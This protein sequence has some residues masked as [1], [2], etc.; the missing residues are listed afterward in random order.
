MVTTLGD[1]TME[2]PDFPNGKFI[3]YHAGPTPS[4]DL[5]HGLLPIR[6]TNEDPIYVLEQIFEKTEL[7]QIKNEVQLE[8]NEEI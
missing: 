8:C 1:W 7:D 2:T 3:N 4:V 5:S 6:K